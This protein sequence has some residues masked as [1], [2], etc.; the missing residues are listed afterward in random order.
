MMMKY[1]IL[2][3]TEDDCQGGADGGAKEPAPTTDELQRN[4]ACDFA[5][6]LICKLFYTSFSVNS[7]T[8]NDDMTGDRIVR[9]RAC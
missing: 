5:S 6:M 7:R 4:Q 9:T 3:T 2:W 1:L 8:I